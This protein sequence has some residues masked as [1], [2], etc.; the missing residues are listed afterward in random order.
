MNFIINIVTFPFR[1]A[2]GVIRFALKTT[3]FVLA[4]FCLIILVVLVLILH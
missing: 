1:L 3:A 4:I 2:F